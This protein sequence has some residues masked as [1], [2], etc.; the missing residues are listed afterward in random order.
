MTI[1]VIENEDGSADYQLTLS[2]EKDLVLAEEGFKFL[3]LKAAYELTDK[4]LYVIL[5]RYKQGIDM[6]QTSTSGPQKR[7]NGVDLPF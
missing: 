7:L 6:K 1:E 2:Q 5:D 3:T 4:Q